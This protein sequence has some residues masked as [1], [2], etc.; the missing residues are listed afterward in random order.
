MSHEL[1]HHAEPKLFFSLMHM[2][3][4]FEF[5]FVFEFELSSQEKIK[6]KTIGISEKKGNPFQ[7]KPAHLSPPPP[8]RLP[9]TCGPRLSAPARA[10]VLP[11]LPLAARWADLSAPV[12][13]AHACLL[14]LSRGP[15]SSALLTIRSP[16]LSLLWATPIETVPQTA[17]ALRRG[18]AHDH[19][20]LGHAPRAKPFLEPA[21]THSPSPAQLCPQSST[22]ALSLALR[23]R[24]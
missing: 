10:R 17:R 19:A 18:C 24:P 12:S 20:F 11:S 13:S 23:V 22:L 15:R 9:V 5:E 3:E 2:F 8:P 4:L 7:P 1:L 14:S 6:R 16:A 21:H